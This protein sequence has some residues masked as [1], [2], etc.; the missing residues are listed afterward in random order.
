M[1]WTCL[2]AMLRLGRLPTKWGDA[3]LIERALTGERAAMRELARRIGPILRARILYATRGRPTGGADVDDLMQDAWGRL[4][5]R[6]AHRLRQYDPARMSLKGYAN[7]IAANA[8][9]AAWERASA[10]KRQPEGGLAPIEAAQAIQDGRDLQANAIERETVSDLWAHLNTTLPP[11]GRLVLKALFV[12]HLSPAASADQLGIKRAT[13]D[14]W[15]FKIKKAAL[16]WRAARKNLEANPV[17]VRE[18]SPR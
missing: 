13:V 18:G 5:E 15:R 3:E 4:F 1:L 14:S 9:G 12:D 6:D 16:A 17:G 10:A 7:L 2:L 11:M 8:V